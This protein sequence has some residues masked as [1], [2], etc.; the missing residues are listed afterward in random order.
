MLGKHLSTKRH[1]KPCKFF[2]TSRCPLSSQECD[3]AHILA[4]EV[5]PQRQNTICR[6]YAAGNCGN[7][8]NCRYRHDVEQPEERGAN[9]L[10]GMTGVD[11]PYSQN[12]SSLSNVVG[13]NISLPSIPLYRSPYNVMYP[14]SPP[15]AW[16]PYGDAYSPPVYS[17]P[18]IVP[19]AQSIKPGVVSSSYSGDSS[20]SASTSTRSSVSEDV[21]F[22]TEDPKYKEHSHQHQSQIRIAE[23]RLVVHVPPFY[24]SKN[25]L[26]SISPASPVDGPHSVHSSKHASPILNY[27]TSPA[28]TPRTRPR[29]NSRYKTCNYKTK[30]CKYFSVH[31]ACPNGNECTFIHEEPVPKFPASATQNVK[32]PPGLPPKPISRQEENRKRNYF[33]VSWRVIGGGVLI[34]DPSHAS[35]SKDSGSH[36]E[37]DNNP[38]NTNESSDAYH[39]LVDVNLDSTGSPSAAGYP[40]PKPTRRPRSSSIPSSTRPAEM[41]IKSLFSAESPGSL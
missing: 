10:P 23:E 11:P 21:T 31:G 40:A 15:G 19:V 34:G 36:A 3:F 17:T 38:Q 16:V 6:Y 5:V 7:G 32:L 37:D 8:P 41:T 26:G 27:S 30:L 25:A 24:S 33:P 18:D 1:T 4:E 14:I 2:Q 20:G 22:V 9:R 35:A 29:S 28:H 12:S 39:G 13:S